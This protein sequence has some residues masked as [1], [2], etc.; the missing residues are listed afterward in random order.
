[1][2]GALASKGGPGKVANGGKTSTVKIGNDP[3]FEL[4]LVENPVPE[5]TTVTPPSTSTVTPP[6]SSTNTSVK[7]GD[8]A[9]VTIMIWLILISIAGI[10]LL[11]NK[12]EI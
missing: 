6:D 5:T 3:E 2:E 9:P 7:T 11:R 1:M 4:E 12:K 8:K 10:V